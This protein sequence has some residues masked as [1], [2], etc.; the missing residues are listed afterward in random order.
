MWYADTTS[1]V[2]AFEA[3]SLQGLSNDIANYFAESGDTVCQLEAVYFQDDHGA[4]ST[5]SDEGLNQFSE[6]C[7]EL[8]EYL[9]S[10]TESE[11]EAMR[12][13]R[14]DYYANTL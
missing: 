5:L 11:A 1:D 9:I 8:N 2:Q 10:E 12:Q 3:E 6:I 14:S 7:G 4:R 13:N